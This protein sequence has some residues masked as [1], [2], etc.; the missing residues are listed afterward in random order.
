[1]CV[2]YTC[3]CNYK[4]WCLDV[5]KVNSH[6][7]RVSHIIT[8]ETNGEQLE[9]RE[10]FS[11]THSQGVLQLTPSAIAV[12]ISLNIG[13]KNLSLMPNKAWVQMKCIW[14][15]PPFFPSRLLLTFLCPPVAWLAWSVREGRTSLDLNFSWVQ[16]VSTWANL[17][18]CPC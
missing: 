10:K 15:I 1:M 8:S 16:S 4:S 14:E 9:A 12:L 2:W 18:K 13:L 7:S 11:F 17:L 6:P 3:H 5:P